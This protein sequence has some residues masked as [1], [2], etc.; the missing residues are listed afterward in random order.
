MGQELTTFEAR[1]ARVLQALRVLS[2]DG[3]REVDQEEQAV[4]GRFR[5]LRESGFGRLEVILL[6]HQVEGINTTRSMKR[7]E[8]ALPAKNC[9]TKPPG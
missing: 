4:L 3:V 1:K 6:D 2:G 9:L 7:R 5:E 8:L